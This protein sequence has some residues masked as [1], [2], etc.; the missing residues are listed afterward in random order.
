MAGLSD[1]FSPSKVFFVSSL[2]G[3]VFNALPVISPSSWELAVSTRVLTGISLAGIY[4]VGMK[5]ASDWRAEGLGNWLGALVGA[6][7]IGT[8]FPHALRLLPDMKHPSLFLVVVSAIAVIGGVLLVVAVP[9]GRFRKK[10][11]V[12][13]FSG[14]GKAFLEKDFRAAAMGYFGHMWELYTFWAFVPWMLRTYFGEYNNDQAAWSFAI[15]AMGSIGCVIGGRMSLKVGSAPVAAFALAASGACCLLSP[16][17]WDIPVAVFLSFMMV[18]GLTVVMD[19]PQ[20]STLVARSAP[21]NLRG[22]AITL[23]TSIGFAITIASIQLL[24][25]VKQIGGVRY[26]FLLLLPGPVFGL[27]ALLPAMKR[28]N[29]NFSA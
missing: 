24:D 6:L 8:A 9:D 2:A 10:S 14:V 17:V 5:I 29:R 15:I 7:V 26:L 21:D 20:F 22:S 25:F 4:P 11:G 13:S 28:Q 23:V 12:F 18:W 3:A 27:I 16:L 19:S 1:R